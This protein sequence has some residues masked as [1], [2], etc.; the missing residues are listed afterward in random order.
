[1]DL[2]ILAVEG[3]PGLSGFYVAAFAFLLPSLESPQALTP[4][5]LD[6]AVVSLRVVLT[7]DGFNLGLHLI[8]DVGGDGN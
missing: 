6:F 7:N 2:K 8:E 1:M 3:Q 5:D 4:D